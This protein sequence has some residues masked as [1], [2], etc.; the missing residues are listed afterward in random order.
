M[1]SKLFERR[2]D[3]YFSVDEGGRTNRL[4]LVNVVAPFHT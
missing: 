1:A 4:T 2:V 3:I